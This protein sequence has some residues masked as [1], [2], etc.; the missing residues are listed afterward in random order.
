MSDKTRIALGLL[1]TIVGILIIVGLIAMLWAI[2]IGV[3]VFVS[4]DAA[5]GAGML[6]FILAAFAIACGLGLLSD[7]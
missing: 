3:F 5:S 4:P 7:W 6:T 1:L 2:S